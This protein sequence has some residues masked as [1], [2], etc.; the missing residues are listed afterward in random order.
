[1]EGVEA[2][3]ET[4]AVAASIETAAIAAPATTAVPTTT[5][6]A[7]AA[8][9]ADDGS[10]TKKGIGGQIRAHFFKS[11]HESAECAFGRKIAH[12]FDVL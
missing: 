12:F 8:A 7:A 11:V 6:A 1:M 2:T 5:A 9:A 10:K 3:A 4:A